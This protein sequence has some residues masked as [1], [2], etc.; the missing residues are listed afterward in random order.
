MS[1]RLLLCD[2]HRIFREGLK[3]LIEGKS[4]LHVVAEAQDGPA[5]VER[6]RDLAP[7]IVVMDISLPKLNGIETTR[8]ILNLRR[9]IKVIVLSMHSDRRFVTEALKAGASGYLVKDSAFD[10]LFAAICAVNDGKTY[11]SPAIAQIV[12]DGCVGRVSPADAAASPLTRREQEVLQLLAEGSSTK[13]IAL[14]I[15]VSI[16][17]I[18]THR[19]HIMAKLD[20]HNVA[21]LT[22]Y[23]IREGIISLR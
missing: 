22:R 9:G 16:K 1:L 12:V 14:R 5:A 10:E 18:E 2:D 19:M 7:D 13:E 4:G 23:A 3:T 6:A 15:G 8:R 21:G 17:T 11:L 20:I